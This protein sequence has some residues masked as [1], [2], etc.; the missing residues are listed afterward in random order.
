MLARDIP[1]YERDFRQNGVDSGGKRFLLSPLTVPI[2]GE[3]RTLAVTR[4]KPASGD[5]SF[6]FTESPIKDRVV[7]H[8]TNGY[9]KGDIEKLTRPNKHVSVPFVLARDGA[10]YNLWSSRYW[11]YHIGPGAVGGNTEMSKSSVGIEIS[12]IGPL[13]RRGNTLMT[14]YDKVYCS[15]SE[16]EF[17]QRRSYRGFD[18]YA[19]YTDIQYSRL[20]D[21]LRYITG[22]F[23]IP[24]QFLP[25]AQRFET[26]PQIARFHGVTSHVNYR[27]DKFDIGP[28]FDWE[29][30]IAGVRR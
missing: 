17:Y 28:A 8:F 2:A 10:I 7:I 23:S 4:C 14:V 5:A 15:V 27:T 11:S 26:T 13:I 1:V 12:N 16:Q 6:Y 30:V 3:N 18:Y 22:K 25:P 9:L 21:L 20:I 29:R 19:T 24:R